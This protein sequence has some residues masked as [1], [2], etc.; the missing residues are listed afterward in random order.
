VFAVFLSDICHVFIL[1]KKGVFEVQFFQD[2][3]EL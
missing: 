3:N 2:F 1:L